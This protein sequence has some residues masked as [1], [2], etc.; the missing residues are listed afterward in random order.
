VKHEKNEGAIRIFRSFAEFKVL[1]LS[2]PKK[3]KSLSTTH[4]FETTCESVCWLQ[5]IFLHTFEH[6]WLTDPKLLLSCEARFF[7]PCVCRDS[8]HMEIEF[9]WVRV[10]VW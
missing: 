5:K 9:G 4:C 3:P 10:G 6:L 1:Y 8:R 7:L 2:L